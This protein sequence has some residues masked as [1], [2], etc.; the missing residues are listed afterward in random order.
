M[1]HRNTLSLV[2]SIA[3]YA[4]LVGASSL[5]FTGGTIIGFDEAANSLQVTRNASVL[6][7]EDRI[8]GVY[9]SEETIQNVPADAEKIDITDK[10]VTPGFI[11]THRHGW[12][13]ALKTL[14]S[15]T[16]LIEYFARYGESVAP[17]IY[18]TEDVYIGQL[19]GL[20]EALNAGVTTT[21]DHAH[22]T[23]SNE[24]AEAGLRASV[25]SN[26]RVFWCYTF[27]NITNFSVRDQL[28]NFRDIAVKA[29]FKG[30]PTSIGIA[31][32]S[33]S[34][35]PMTNEVQSVIELAK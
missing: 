5:L 34:P 16:N 9:S 31:Y 35:N 2:S 13:T 4:N 20:Y 26:A 17:E 19:A 14:G 30:S 25:D 12:Q 7:S 3:L 22:H 6:V 21:L 23:W 28:S 11:D 29:I 32:D 27:H 1:Y 10:I 24:T 33:W 15:N 18:T 8:V